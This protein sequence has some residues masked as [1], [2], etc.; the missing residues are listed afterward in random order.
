VAG[1]RCCSASRHVTGLTY[2]TDST[3]RH[4]A[5]QTVGRTVRPAVRLTARLTVGLTTELRGRVTDLTVGNLG[6]DVG[7]LVRVGGAGETDGQED[8]Q[9]RG[10]K[11]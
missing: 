10:G 5:G 2:P 6:G 8:R 7:G 11:A 4:L 1:A 3:D 9:A